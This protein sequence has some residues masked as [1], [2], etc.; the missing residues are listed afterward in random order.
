[1]LAGL[2]K[3]SEENDADMVLANPILPEDVLKGK[4][5]I[6]RFLLNTLIEPKS[7]SL[8]VNIGA[9]PG[10]IRTADHFLS[11]MKRLIEYVKTRLRVQHVVQETPARFLKDIQQ[12]VC[13]ERKPLR[14]CAERLAS[15]M[16]T[17]EITDMTDYGGLIVVSNS[18]TDCGCFTTRDFNN[19]MGS[20][21]VCFRFHILQRSFP[22]TQ[23][24]SR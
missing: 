22:H 18:Y 9:V 7:S 10:N 8:L 2:R 13:I 21:S 11:F 17:L 1:M 20:F 4:C 14:F 19:F 6:C 5:N 24:D 16:R 23:K 12:K 15:L 3:A